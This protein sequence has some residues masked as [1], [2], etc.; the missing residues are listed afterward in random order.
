MELAVNWIYGTESVGEGAARREGRRKTPERCMD[1]VKED[2]EKV[3][4]TVEET[5]E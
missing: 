1:V 5:G 2:M 3:G 4:V